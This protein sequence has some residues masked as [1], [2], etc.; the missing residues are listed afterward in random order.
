MS[1]V[2]LRTL[3]AL[4]WAGAASM[5]G[6]GVRVST[7]H[8]AVLWCNGAVI[9]A[10]VAATLTM[11]SIVK[12]MLLAVSRDNARATAMAVGVAVGHVMRDE[13]QLVTPRRGT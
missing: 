7:E 12:Q 11:W 4:V 1:V 9:V 6:M 10:L 3:A 2:G 8:H 5:M 13:P